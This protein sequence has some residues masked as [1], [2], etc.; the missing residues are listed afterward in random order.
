M[1]TTILVPTDYSE[2]S[3]NALETAII[4]AKRNNASIHLLHINDTALAGEDSYAIKNA[5]QIAHAIADNI[6][7]R[8]GVET[9]VLFT[10]GFVGPTIVKGALEIKPEL[11][12]MGAYGASGHRDLFIGSNSYY[13]IKHASCPVLIVPEGKR[14]QRFN[15]VLFP[16]RPTLGVFKKYQF[17]NDLV[18]QIDPDCNF[19]L[20]G[21][22]IDRKE[23]DVK[24]ATEIVNELKN[25]SNGAVT[26]TISYSYGRN[27]SEEVLEKADKTKTDLIV[28][29]STVDVA[30]KPFFIG[31]FSQRIISHARTP[32]LSVFRT[33]EN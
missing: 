23:H 3:F 30:N 22:S 11:I 32:V 4:I 9:R 33:A 15:Q 29:C 28:I 12:V 27:I 16:F 18:L 6:K 5:T 19:E 26:Y 2:A 13:T 7:Q 1:I 24:Q 14:W 20:F 31:P 8:H 17:I 25:M 10:D 21:I